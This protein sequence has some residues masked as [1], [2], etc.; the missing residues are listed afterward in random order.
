V[1][2]QPD[3]KPGFAADCPCQNTGCTIWGN[4]LECVRGHRLNQTHLPECLQPLMR[5]LVEEM[6]RKVEYRVVDCRPGASN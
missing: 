2:S 4:C 3:E 1:T 5:G 6:A